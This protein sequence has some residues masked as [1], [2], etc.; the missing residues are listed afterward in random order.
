[1]PHRDR[2]SSDN[3]A[4]GAGCRPVWDRACRGTGRRTRP[5]MGRN[6]AGAGPGWCGTGQRL[7]HDRLPDRAGAWAG[8][9]LDAGA[10]EV[11]MATQSRCTRAPRNHPARDHPV[12]G[13]SGSFT[14]SVAHFRE[15]GP[16]QPP[17]QT[18]PA[19]VAG[20]P[21]SGI[22][23][24]SRNISAFFQYV[25]STEA[26]GRRN[27][28]SEFGGIPLAFAAAAP[29]TWRRGEV[30]SLSDGSAATTSWWVR[31]GRSVKRCLQCR[32]SSGSVISVWH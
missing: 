17:G 25:T 23:L 7:M 12:S 32:T 8:N 5:G 20:H 28:V 14:P 22:D 24:G 9:R 31:P 4:S 6:Q 1:M 21:V 27:H 11:N 2:S 10:W 15:S 16:V 19:R 3:R 30:R 26:E 18:A 13:V 29:G